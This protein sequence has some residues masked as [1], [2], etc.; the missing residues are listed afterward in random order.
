M[1][2]HSARA[3]FP[4]PGH[5]HADCVADLVARAGL[6]FDRCGLKLTPLRRRVLEEVA[7]VHCPIGAYDI[8][9]RLSLKGR[10]I[11]PISVYRALEALKEAGLIHRLESRNAFFACHATHPALS[12]Q[13]VL[14]C[15]T[16]GSVAEVSGD[17]A[18]AAIETAAG[19]GRFTA[20]TILV[21]AMGRCG[22]CSD[23]KTDSSHH[24]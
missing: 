9:E 5:D 6:A 15:E 11:A 24:G 23:P 18:F 4:S 17:V 3:A 2:D 1:H 7:G 8:L 20:K 12:R 21:E 22:N 16:C 14:V 10:R 19:A 13:L